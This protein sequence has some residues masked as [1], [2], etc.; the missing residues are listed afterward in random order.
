MGSPGCLLISGLAEPVVRAY[1]LIVDLV[2]RYDSSQG[3]RM[4]AGARG[5]GESL[6]SRRAF[7]DLVERW[8]DRHTLDLLVLPVSVKEI[9]LELVRE[10]R[11]NMATAAAQETVMPQMDMDEPEVVDQSATS[12]NRLSHRMPAEQL[13]TSLLSPGSSVVPTRSD[14]GSPLSQQHQGVVLPSATPGREPPDPFFRSF[15]VVDGAPQGQ[16]EAADEQQGWRGSVPQEVMDEASRMEVSAGAEAGGRQGDLGLLLKFFTAMGFKE[17]TVNRVLSRT[18]PLDPCDLLELVQQEQGLEDRGGGG[19]EDISRRSGDG[20]EEEPNFSGRAVEKGALSYSTGFGDRSPGE[21]LRSSGGGEEKGEVDDD[22]VLGVVKR[23]AASCGYPEDQVREV[24]SNLPE[25]SSHQLLLE[26]QRQGKRDG[27]PLGTN[28]TEAAAA[29]A[30]ATLTAQQRAKES[31]TDSSRKEGGEVTRR[32]E[33]ESGAL[34]VAEGKA[35]VDNRNKDKDGVSQGKLLGRQPSAKAM[36]S[37]DSDG[38]VEHREI[39]KFLIDQAYRNSSQEASAKS[40]T[41]VVTE[42]HDNVHKRPPVAGAGGGNTRTQNWNTLHHQNQQ[43]HPRGPSRVDPTRNGGSSSIRGPPRPRYPHEMHFPD[44]MNPNMLA[45]MPGFFSRPHQR[46][47]LPQMGTGAIVTGQQR[48]LEGLQMP[49]ELK[50]SGD[51]GDSSLRQI[52]IDGSNVAM[53]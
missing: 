23:A 19:E 9:L 46:P 28:I 40:A 37:F 48:F 43:N 39:E 10:S 13:D 5:T 11:W 21:G 30:T 20:A 12:M 32:K 35:S 8:D 41:P 44:Q 7:K 36:A 34:R 25:L 38:L 42:S 29:A 22:F 24:F 14:V 31:L 47:G 49:F 33:E 53:R 18:G 15:A 26:L 3:R 6:D 1:S 27:K 2:E 45:A 4:D 16:V 17:D 52:I 50:L 51:T